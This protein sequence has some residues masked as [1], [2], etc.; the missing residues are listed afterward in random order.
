MSVQIVLPLNYAHV[1]W[2]AVIV[3]NIAVLVLLP[4]VLAILFEYW[5]KYRRYFSYA[6]R[7]GYRRY[8]FNYFLTIFDT[9]TFVVSALVKS[10]NNNMTV[11]ERVKARTVVL[12]LK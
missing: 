3:V 7:C 4:I 9:S 8:F 12:H 11:T 10:V 6:Y 5:H 1:L 2:L